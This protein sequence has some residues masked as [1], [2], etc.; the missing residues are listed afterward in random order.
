MNEII[1][2]GPEQ[3]RP[4][5]EL[6]FINSY[7]LLHYATWLTYPEYSK[8]DCVDLSKVISAPGLSS[9]EEAKAKLPL[10]Y[11]RQR[12]EML[13]SRRTTPQNTVLLKYHDGYIVEG[14]A[15]I[16]VASAKL[17]QAETIEANVIPIN[18][19]QIHARTEAEKQIM[20][21][22]RNMGLWTGEVNSDSP[23]PDWY[24]GPWVFARNMEKAKEVFDKIG[25]T[26]TTY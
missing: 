15:G 9:W 24:E 1:K 2:P 20:E 3:E 25:N 8:V 7:D 17:L 10:D 4:S 23:T 11:L 14:N 5:N 19:Y 6:P 13:R 18:F 26:S 12:Y 21:D 22:R 16:Y